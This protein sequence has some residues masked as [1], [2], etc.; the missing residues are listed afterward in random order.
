M[1]F[2]Y[3]TNL[4]TILISC[5]LNLFFFILA[6]KGISLVIT[7]HLH[8]GPQR[9]H[10]NPTPR[11]GGFGIFVALSVGLLLYNPK[12]W[13]YIIVSLPVFLSGFIE[14]L[15]RSLHP[16]MR[17]IL[18]SVG[19]TAAFFILDVKITKVD[20]PLIDPIL[21]IS[22][23]SFLFT[24]F[25]LV[26]LSNAIN[27]IDGFNGLASGVSIMILLAITY[28]ANNVGDFLVRDLSIMTIFALL[29]FFILNFPF[30][31][32]FLGD[33]GA[34][35]IGFWIGV[36]VVL[37]VK[38]NPSVSPWFAL[39]V[40]FYPVYDVLFSIYRRKFIQEKS[41]FDPDALHLHTIIYRIFI[42]RK[43][44]IQN[45]VL[46]NSL[47]S[48]FLWILNLF[49]VVPA[50]VFYSNTLYLVVVCFIFAVIYNLTYKNLIHTKA[51]PFLK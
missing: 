51:R 31:K 32:I 11:I 27:I 39:A 4:I 15:T 44:N 20:V 1:D 7:D 12:F 48:I 50:V 26:G 30:G 35:F 46:Q 16:K 2:L 34:Y 49:A 47:T 43:F 10:E 29:G 8:E 28:V 6:K 19:A 41:A 3:K 21:S 23:I 9:F 37:L 36:L 45:K 18:M 38:N 14:D 24:V 40:S 17:L 22:L 42:S 25:A 13:I 33:G 5:F